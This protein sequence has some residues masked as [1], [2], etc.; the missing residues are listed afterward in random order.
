MPGEAPYSAVHPKNPP[1]IYGKTKSDGEEAILAETRNTGLG[2]VLRVPVLYGKVGVHSGA[3]KESSVN[4]L[5]DSVRL[6]T[7][8]RDTERITTIDD[9]S[10][11]Y[12]TNT[13]DVAR[14]LL[15]LS[16][17]YLDDTMPDPMTRPKIL[18]FT[19]EDAMTKYQICQAFAEILHQDISTKLVP[20]KDDG[21]SGAVKRPYDCHLSTKELEGLGV[22]VGTLDFVG[23]WYGHASMCESLI[24]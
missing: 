20:L 6:A 11:R 14:V 5:L 13:Q 17:V 2:V 10:I 15:E 7:G 12:P 19:S 18:Q 21:G 1:N 22:N 24:Y 23:W 9:W 8:S 4:M 3:N 16:N